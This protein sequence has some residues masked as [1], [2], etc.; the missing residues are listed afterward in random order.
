M[1]QAYYEREK[2][3][4]DDLENDQQFLN[5]VYLF[6]QQRTGRRIYD[7][8]ERIDEFMELFRQI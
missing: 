7:K 8:D 2:L 4:R 3:T 5:D 1:A 6:M